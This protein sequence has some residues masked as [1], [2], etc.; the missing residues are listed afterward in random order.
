MAT[1]KINLF[2]PATLAAAVNYKASSD[3]L[4]VSR[5]AFLGSV[6]MVDKVTLKNL[7]QYKE[8]FAHAYLQCLP[9]EVQK[10][11]AN[12]ALKGSEMVKT[13]TGK[14]ITIEA[15]SSDTVDAIKAKIQDK[16]GIPPGPAAPDLR[17]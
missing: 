13:L 6:K 17:W 2:K 16:E 14:T 9:D 11:L 7:A 8:A 10:V 1:S 12:K 4:M 15:E 5:T 3:G